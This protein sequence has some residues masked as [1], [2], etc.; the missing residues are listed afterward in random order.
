MDPSSFVNLKHKSERLSACY[1]EVI[2]NIRELNELG[3]LPNF[4]FV[5]NI[6][7]GDSTQNM[8]QVMMCNKGIVA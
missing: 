7:G 5:D 6:S 4:V 2:D 3:D 8:V 1:K